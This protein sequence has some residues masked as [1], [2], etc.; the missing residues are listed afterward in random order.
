MALLGFP[1]W[2][3]DTGN[4]PGAQQSDPRPCHAGEQVVRQGEWEP[5]LHQH[6]L[7]PYL[8]TAISALVFQEGQVWHQPVL[9]SGPCARI[10]IGLGGPQLTVM[11]S[12]KGFTA[13]WVGSFHFPIIHFQLYLPTSFSAPVFTPRPKHW[14]ITYYTAKTVFSSGSPYSE[15]KQ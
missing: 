13:W 14:N 10:W 15:R 12:W 5:P 6:P 1:R 9:P 11:L 3:M 2:E 4:P 8:G 7:W